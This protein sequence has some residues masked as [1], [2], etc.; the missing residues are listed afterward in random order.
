VLPKHLHHPCTYTYKP[1]SSTVHPGS[2][3][4]ILFSPETL[5]HKSGGALASPP[6]A[7]HS[8][9]SE[10][11]TTF[12]EG[13]GS[14]I[15]TAHPTPLHTSSDTKHQCHPVRAF[16]PSW[17]HQ[18]IITT[19]STHGTLKSNCTPVAHP[20]AFSSSQ[21]T[22]SS[23]C[24]TARFCKLW[25]TTQGVHLKKGAC[26]QEYSFL[27]CEHTVCTSF[28]NKHNTACAQIVCCKMLL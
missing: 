17:Q 9:F 18:N 16:W 26:T 1:Q 22:P 10:R 24:T 20:L 3:L 21:M 19:L 5:S 4:F 28:R 7:F 11:F 14:C 12:H 2:H 13:G 25:Y 27:P 15:L 23:C 8:M 6:D